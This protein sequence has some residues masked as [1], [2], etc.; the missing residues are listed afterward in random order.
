MVLSIARHSGRGPIST[1]AAHLTR[2]T[3][4]T[5]ELEPNTAVVI[6]S[7][8]DAVESIRGN[9]GIEKKR[10]HVVS[11]DRSYRVYEMMCI[12]G[13]LDESIMSTSGPKKST[14]TIAAKL[15]NA[16]IHEYS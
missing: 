2:F 11:K 8:K 13:W 1:E 14:T 16:G 4:K 10:T 15:E 3:S 7:S 9:A 6:S 5:C 12:T